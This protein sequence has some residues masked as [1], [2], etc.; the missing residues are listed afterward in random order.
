M[1]IREICSSFNVGG[2]FISCS[3]L[4]TGNINST[5][6]VKYIRDGE[7]KA[8]T[9]Q[10]INKNVFKNPEQV[11]D[12]IIKVTDFVRENIR[13]RG[14]ST[15]KFAMRAFPTIDG[16][17]YFVDD[18]GDYWRC[19]RFIPNSRTYDS[20][21]DLEIIRRA[22]EAFGRFQSCLDGF[23]ANSLYITIPDFHNTKKRYS[24]FKK[25]IE[26]D[27]FDRVKVVSEEIETL[28]S[29]E[30]EATLLQDMLDRKEIPLRVTHNDTKCNNVSFDKV[31]NEALAVLDLDTVM[32]GAIAHDFGDAI[33]FVANSVEEDYPDLELV[34]L[35]LDKYEAF[36][37]GF[38]P[39]I[40]ANITEKEK[41]TLNLGVF[42]MTSELASRFLADYILGDTYF[43]VK[44]PGHNLDRAR[45]QIAL[46]KNILLKK[47]QMDK[48]I[49]KYF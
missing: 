32:P 23:D 49:K 1:T 47:D 26:E 37:K 20:T 40:I 33:R 15:K 18:K 24:D 34:K 42:A 3:E 22:G 2:R 19:Y 43:R 5:Y 9:V 17:F 4:G 44:Y 25:A 29:F 48:I 14:L 38:V 12:N 10:R 31:T 46:A 6:L 13:S 28:L 16:K 21:D 11:M 8:Y 27:P 30:K 35:N 39:E 36:T 45:N 41:E 7:D